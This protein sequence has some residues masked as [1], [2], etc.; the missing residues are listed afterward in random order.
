MP[1]KFWCKHTLPDTFCVFEI[2]L[3]TVFFRC[4]QLL[5]NDANTS[6]SG[7]VG[8]PVIQFYNGW[9]QL[10]VCVANMRK[11]DWL[12]KYGSNLI[13][14]HRRYIYHKLCYRV[15]KPHASIHYTIVSS[16][17]LSL[18]TLC[19][20][21]QNVAEQNWNLIEWKSLTANFHVKHM[22]CM[23]LIIYALFLWVKCNEEHFLKRGHCT[24]I[25]K[26]WL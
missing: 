18:S 17:M 6:V 26:H 21:K 3:K 5:K 10:Y 7:Y 22:Q 15:E 12:L 11:I 23:L 16:F 19:Q 8:S 13:F 20:G 9:F 1:K 14:W 25:Q 2:V 4:Y 24:V